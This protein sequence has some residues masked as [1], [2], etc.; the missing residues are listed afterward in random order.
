MRQP[1][2]T[3]KRSRELPESG[4]YLPLIKSYTFKKEGMKEDIEFVGDH[5]TF[6]E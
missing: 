2:G 1:T 5:N 4:D 6:A 3:R